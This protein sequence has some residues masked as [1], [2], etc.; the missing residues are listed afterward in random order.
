MVGN[1]RNHVVLKISNTTKKV[2]MTTSIFMV[3]LRVLDASI[4]VQGRNI[5]MFVDNRAAQLEHISFLWN[6]Q[7]VHYPQTFSS[8]TSTNNE[9]THMAFSAQMYCVMMVRGVAAVERRK[10]EKN[11][12][13]NH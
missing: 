4:G 10:R 8:Y 13:L 5:F 1:H 11:V 12:T 3:F 7:F 2:W 9:L 6:T